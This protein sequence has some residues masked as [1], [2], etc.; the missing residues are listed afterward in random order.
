MVDFLTFKSFIARDFF[1]FFY[2]MGAVGMPLLFL[3]KKSYLLKKFKFLQDFYNYLKTL[4]SKLTKKQQV[5]SILISISFFLF[6]ELMW[7]VAFEFVIGYF[8]IVQGAVN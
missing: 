2:Y 6:L 7:R 1:I 8:T 3:A 4:F 5:I